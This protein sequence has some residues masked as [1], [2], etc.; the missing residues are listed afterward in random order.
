PAMVDER[1]VDAR[2]LLRNGVL[3]LLLR[4]D[5]KHGAAARGEV[6]REVLG[7]LQQLGRLLEVDD[8]DAAAL[9]EDE[10]AHLGVPAASLVAEV[11]AGLEQLA[12]RNACHGDSSW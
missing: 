4:A 12:H 7:L 9:R 1:H 3:G 2:S 6:P 11:H 5:E 8:V 10:A